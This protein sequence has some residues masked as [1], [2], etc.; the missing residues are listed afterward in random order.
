M[1]AEAASWKLKTTL[2]P[3]V[4]QPVAPTD[5]YALVD[6]LALDGSFISNPMTVD[7][8]ESDG[9]EPMDCHETQDK[10]AEPRG[11]R[12]KIPRRLR[13][14]LSRAATVGRIIMK[15]GVDNGEFAIMVVTN[16]LSIGYTEE[17]NAGGASDGMEIRQDTKGTKTTFSDQERGAAVTDE[18]AEADGL[19]TSALNTFLSTSEL[20]GRPSGPPSPLFSFFS[21]RQRPKRG[22]K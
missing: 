4:T 13:S 2:V 14:W 7:L 15:T 5:L 6:S 20:D 11:R 1:A 12:A 19:P 3:S 16:V 21:K 10:A 18:T 8:T 9:E 22:Q 17:S